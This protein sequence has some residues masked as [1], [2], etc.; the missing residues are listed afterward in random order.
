M[1]LDLYNAIRADVLNAASGPKSIRLDQDN[2]MPDGSLRRK[3]AVH[4]V[5]LLSVQGVADF[6]NLF[7]GAII[8]ASYYSRFGAIYVGETW[9]GDAKCKYVGKF[10]LEHSKAYQAIVAKDGAKL[11]Q[12]DALRFL[13]PFEGA[14]IDTV[15]NAIHNVKFRKSAE[16]ASVIE[17]GKRSVSRSQ[18]ASLTG[19]GDVPKK[20]AFTIPIWENFPFEATIEYS[21]FVDAEAEAFI[22]SAKHG[23]FEEATQLGEEAL[24]AELTKLAPGVTWIHGSF[25]A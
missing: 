21:V 8:T 14:S 5:E 9:N 23:Q 13:S 24:L 1:Y 17:S 2:I 18:E 19:S 16:G 11:S 22:F 6:V 4:S 25:N 7:G 3:D 12:A 10:A 15:V 20:C